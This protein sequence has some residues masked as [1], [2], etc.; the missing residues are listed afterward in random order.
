MWPSLEEDFANPLS[1]QYLAFEWLS[2]N[3]NLNFFSDEKN[4]QRFVLAT[5]YFSTNGDD[6]TNKDLWLTDEDECNWYSSNI[7]LSQCNELGYYRYLEL[8]FNGLSGTIPSELALLSDSLTRIDLMQ[9]EDASAQV[10]TGHMPSELGALALLESISLGENDLSGRIPTEF[11]KWSLASFLDLK[12]NNLIDEIPSE[13]GLLVALSSL[14]LENNHLSV[15]PS[16]IG[17]LR[18]LR[19]LDLARNEF[20]GSIPK[21]I[22]NLVVLTS[23]DL[24]NNLI[25]G[26]IP[27]ELAG[28]ILLSKSFISGQAIHAIQNA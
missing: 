13:I 19:D 25:I 9:D 28:A 22:G 21:E 26:T 14:N 24:G 18:L 16:E 6:W 27:T 15:I 7:Y 12:N 2:N 23:L 10:I 11:G 4:M 3:G 8:N 1:P 17:N 20:G 5:F